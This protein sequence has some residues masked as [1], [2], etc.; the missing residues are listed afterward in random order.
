DGVY[1]TSATAATLT[2]GSA[3][4][5]DEGKY[6]VDAYNDYGVTE[7]AEVSLTVNKVPQFVVQPVATTTL[8]HGTDLVLSVEAV[9]KPEA[10]YRWKKDG[11]L[12]AGASG[13]TL[14]VSGVAAPEGGVYVAEAYNSVGSA[15]S[16]NAVVTVLAPPHFT[17]QPVGGSVNEGG[18]YALKPTLIGTAPMSYVWKKDGVVVAGGVVKDL[19][20]SPV[21]R[22]SGGVYTLEA[23]N[24]YGTTVSSGASVV[25]REMVRITKQPEGL[26]VKEGEDAVLSVECTGEGPLSY[27]WMRNG[28]AIANTNSASLTLAKAVPANAGT[29]MVKVTNM[30]GS[31]TSTGA[32]LGVKAAPVITKAP[33]GGS[34]LENRSFTMSVEASGYAPL[35]YAWKKDGVAISGASGASYTIASMK[36]ADAGVYTVEVSNEVKSVSSAGANVSAFLIPVVTQGPVGGEVTYGGTYTLSVVASGG[37]PLS[38]QWMKGGVAMSGKTASSLAI[39]NAVDANTGSYS[40]RVTNA[41]GSVTSG[42]VNVLVKLL[43]PVIVKQP[44]DVR[45]GYKGSV[46]LSVGATAFGPINYQWSRVVDEADATKDVAI[47]GATGANYV[48]S[49]AM[50]AAVGK[51]RVRLS[52]AAGGVTSNAAGLSLVYAP[53]IGQQPSGV[54]VWQGQSGSFEVGVSGGTAPYDYQWFKNGVAMAGKTGSSLSI[55]SVAGTDGGIY[56]VRVSNLGGSVTSAGA[57]LTVAVAPGVVKQPVATSVGLGGSGSLSVVASGSGP[58]SY[59]WYKDGVAMSGK[60][61]AVLGVSGVVKGD[62][63]M[64]KVEVSNT[65]VGETRKVESVE[66]RLTVVEPA[67]IGEQPVGFEVWEGGGGTLK[68]VVSGGTAP[69]TYQWYRNGVAVAGATSTQLVLSGLKGA[70]AGSYTVRA[71]NLGGVVES[72]VAEVKV[73]VGP[74]VSVQPKEVIGYGGSSVSFGVVAG[75]SGPLSYQ[76]MKD[77]VELSGATEKDLVIGSVGGGDKGMYKV[78]ISNTFLGVTKRVTSREVA[79]LVATLPTEFVEQPV[80]GVVA[81]GGTLRVETRTA[82]GGISSGGL[83]KVVWQK[84]VGGVVTKDIVTAD[85]VSV[86]SW[87]EGGYVKSRMEVN[88]NA[89]V[90]GGVM[91]EGVGGAYRVMV[92]IGNDLGMA[93][94]AAVSVS[95]NA[96]T[97]SIVFPEIGQKAAGSGAFGLGVGLSPSTN[98]LSAE[99]EVLA[100]GD[101]IEFTGAQ[102]VKPVAGKA[103]VVV[104]RARQNGKATVRSAEDVVRTFMVMPE[105]GLYGKMSVSRR[106]NDGVLGSVHGVGVKADGSLWAWG[107]NGSGQLGLGGG[108]VGETVLV[109]EVVGSWSDWEEVSAGDNFTVGIRR[110]EVLVGGVSQTR[111]TLWAW[112]G[113]ESGQLGVG[114]VGMRAE[115]VQ[116]GVLTDWVKVS[117]GRDFVMG[118]R[119]DGSLWGWGSNGSGQLGNGTMVGSRVPVQVGALK[120]WKGVSAGRGHVLGVRVDGSMWAWGWNGFGQLGVGTTRDSAVPVRVGSGTGWAEAY[121]GLNSSYGR[122]VDGRL[123]AWGGNAS[124]QLGDGSVVQRLVPVGVSGGMTWRSVSVGREHVLGVGTDGVLRGWGSNVNAQLGVVLSGRTMSMVPV[125]VDGATDWASVC[126]GDAQGYGMKRGGGVLAWGNGKLGQLGNGLSGANLLLVTTPRNRVE[127]A[128]VPESAVWKDGVVTVTSVMTP[129]TQWSSALT[130]VSVRKPVIGGP[131]WT[132]NGAAVDGS[133]WTSAPGNVLGVVNGILEGGRMRMVTV[134]SAASGVRSELLTGV[135]VVYPQAGLGRYEARTKLNYVTAT[136]QQVEIGSGEGR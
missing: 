14:L 4:L 81:N 30:V 89:V 64:Y 2:I 3:V 11:V 84:V 6:S 106:L 31:V 42:S 123:S 99:V 21:L 51:Y 97:Q 13:S 120:V 66:A 128:G 110:S 1:L 47:A 86:R 48:V 12:I 129:Y 62:E 8:M 83:Y 105:G 101:V 135:L 121:A 22:T 119:S 122:G 19:T 7:S 17:V 59:Q 68:V 127:F 94:S 100:G 93:D 35:S 20:V 107:G 104:I 72:A 69:F 57:A 76:W 79:L 54:T 32:V 29:Y 71:S 33:V 70:Q 108:R 46:T 74:S 37:A 63:G 132:V 102:T 109:P 82:L 113:N 60:T 55:G 34:V 115:P 112:G 73:Y 91:A 16:A 136:G 10:Q 88:R 45:V 28:V 40:V 50:E 49:N 15:V 134:R 65:F 87:E 92:R 111:R 44:V 24:A 77:G 9:G 114:D 75:G 52:N 103:G 80:G 43:P 53:V 5:G 125:A 130:D 67:V 18:T 26:V 78:V 38:Y 23:T 98:G 117:A 25:V 58:L 56:T 36:A 27:V 116:V 126:A 96:S 39:T 61:G 95:G 133:G 85:G 41:A 90:S 131:W 118:L 124:G